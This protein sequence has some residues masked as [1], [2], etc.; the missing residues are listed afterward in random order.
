MGLRGASGAGRTLAP[1]PWWLRA[2]LLVNVV[3]DVGLGISGLLSPRHILIP[4]KGL[5]PLNARF[6]GS[7]Y[8]GGGIVILLAAL[9]RKAIDTRIALYSLFVITALVLGMTF[10]YWTAFTVDGVPKLWMI[11]YLVD[12]VAVPVILVALGL[13]RP[14]AP[15]RHRLTGLFLAEAGVLG[16]AGI[17]LI[18][19]SDA[20]LTA[21]PWTVGPLLAR[22]YGSFLL[23]FG[24]GALLAAVERRSA[25]VRPFLAGSLALLVCTLVTSLLHLDRFDGGAVRWMWFG[26]HAVGLALFTA[27]LAAVI[28][29]HREELAVGQP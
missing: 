25:A 2:F 17:A 29:P 16:V 26:G 15:G 9:V 23:A 10:A 22:V 6:V 13:V 20:V 18:I 28:R 12:P 11:T 24:V 3:Q 27:A 14:A 5:T 19:A 21:W 7:L 1:V 8:L 4:L